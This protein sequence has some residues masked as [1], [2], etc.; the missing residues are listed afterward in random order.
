M[1]VAVWITEEPCDVQAEIK[2]RAQ[3]TCTGEGAGK[4]EY[5]WLRSSTRNGTPKFVK[6]TQLGV[7]PFDSLSNLDNGY[8][9]CQVE[10]HFEHVDSRVVQVKPMLAH[11]LE[12]ELCACGVCALVGRGGEE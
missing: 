2:Q 10:N 4:I 8:Y 6:K 12:G 1:S 5:M 11:A 9:Q 7:L 3:L